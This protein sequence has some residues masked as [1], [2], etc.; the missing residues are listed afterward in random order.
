M[1]ESDGPETTGEAPAEERAEVGDDQLA[2]LR[3][4]LEGVD[5]LPLSQRVELFE[6]ANATLATELAALDEV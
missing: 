2:A 3:A 5:E 1:A 6:R 4:E